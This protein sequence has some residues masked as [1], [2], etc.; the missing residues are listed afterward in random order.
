[1]LPGERESGRY[2]KIK[3]TKVD[4]LSVAATKNETRAAQDILQ[5][6]SVAEKDWVRHKRLNAFHELPV[7]KHQLSR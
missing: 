3:Q 1:M 6:V 4:V 5:S 7:N 2:N